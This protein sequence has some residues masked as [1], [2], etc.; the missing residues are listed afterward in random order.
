MPVDV[1][2]GRLYFADKECLAVGR[3][4]SGQAHFYITWM[5]FSSNPQS[6]IMLT[7]ST[8]RRQWHALRGVE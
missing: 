5:Y 6:P 3:H 7:D 8:D 4:A 2:S 1:G